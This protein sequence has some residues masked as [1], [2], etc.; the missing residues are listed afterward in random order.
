MARNDI[1]FSD[2]TPKTIDELFQYKKLGTLSATA[3]AEIRRISNISTEGFSEADVREEI[4][5]PILR[6]LGYQKG[7]YSSVD[8]EKHLKFLSASKYVDYS[9]KLFEQSH[10]LVEAKKPKGSRRKFPDKDILQALQYAVHPEIDAALLV[11]SDGNLFEVFDREFNLSEPILSFKREDL[12]SRFQDL[13]LLLEPWQSWFFQKRRLLRRASRILD[14]EVN[15]TRAEELSAAF[16]QLL[17]KSR[18][19]IWQNTRENISSE[20]GRDTWVRHL[21]SCDIFEAVEARYFDHFKTGS[22]YTALSKNV[23]KNFDKNPYQVVNRIFPRVARDANIEFW[24]SALSFMLHAE[25]DGRD[26][27]Y[28]PPWL[29][30]E[31]GYAQNLEAALKRLIHHCLTGFEDEPDRQIM[32]LLAS[33]CRRLAKMAVKLIPSVSENS[34]I[35]N[36]LSRFR[37]D[38]LDWLQIISSEAHENL[39]AYYKAEFMIPAKMIKKFAGDSFK[40]STA[41]KYLIDTWKTEL[42]GL[43]EFPDYPRLRAEQ[44]DGEVHPTE[45]MQVTYDYL[46][47]LTLCLIE[48]FPK[49]KSYVLSNHANEIAFQSAQGLSKA[50]EFAGELDL[51]PMRPK[52]VRELATKRFFLGQKEIHKA[53]IDGYGVHDRI[54][55]AK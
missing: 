7:S 1:Y 46:G 36:I 6:V 9:L 16:D 24:G 52:Q 8:R 39:D 40:T 51:A 22:D 42:A 5:N 38:E 19:K 27:K 25:K 11:L 45:C 35:S 12:P 2:N 29:A 21:E 32:M 28:F 18:Q 15:I 23:I 44:S 48:K 13:R 53:L 54:F 20:K 10:W 31:A 49:W 33:A 30:E 3:D 37:R 34:K 43:R 47:H 14:K 55:S 4:I 26:F 41:K 17:S 50:Q